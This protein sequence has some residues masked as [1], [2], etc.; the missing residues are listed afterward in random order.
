M[1]NGAMSRKHGKIIVIK[2]KVATRIGPV[3]LAD[4]PVNKLKN[5]LRQHR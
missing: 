3:N 1:Y 4:D 5:K 2:Q